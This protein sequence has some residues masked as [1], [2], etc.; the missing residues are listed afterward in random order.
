MVKLVIVES[1][2]KAKLIQKFLGDEYIVKACFG[3]I[4]NL[5]EKELGI[6]IENGFEPTYQI[7]GDKKKLVAELKELA[8]KSDQV[9]ISSDEDFEG[10]KIGYDLIKQFKLPFDASNRVVFHEITKPAILKAF[11]S[12]QKLNINRANCALSRRIADRLIGYKI[13]PMLWKFLKGLGSGLSAGRVQSAAVKLVGEKEKEITEKIENDPESY[14]RGSGEF[15]NKNGIELSGSLNPNLPRDN[16]DDFLKNIVK[17]KFTISDINEKEEQRNPPPP[18]VTVSLQQDASVKL[19]QSPKQIMSMAQKLYENGKITY[20]RTDSTLLSEEFLAK[21]GDYI[22]T[23]YG[24]E[25]HRYFQYKT[26]SKSAQEAHEAIRPTNVDCLSLD[27]EKFTDKEIGLYQLI[28][29]RTVQSQMSPAKYRIFEII[30]NISNIEEH[31]YDCRSEFMIFDGFHKIDNI[32]KEL[33]SK[34]DE[35]S[36]PEKSANCS[37][38]SLDEFAKIVS[39]LKKGEEFSKVKLKLDE[40]FPGLPA[41]YTE[42]TLIKALETHGIGRPSTM[43]SIISTI[44]EKSYVEKKNF[45]GI[46][47]DIRIIE[48]SKKNEIKEKKKTQKIG[49][50]KN[51]LTITPIGA[52]IIRFLEENFPEIIDYKFTSK[53]EKYL[54]KI[55]DGKYEWKDIIAKLWSTIEPKLSE[56]EGQKVDSSEIKKKIA[57]INGGEPEKKSFEL[58][59]IS[60]EKVIVR[61]ARY[62][63]VIQVGTEKGNIKYVKIPSDLL[64][65]WE[66]LDFD[67]VKKII[68]KDKLNTIDN[69]GTKSK[70]NGLTFDEK[71]VLI[72]EGKYG[73]YIQFDGKNYGLGKLGLTKQYGNQVSIPI[74]IVKEKISSLPEDNPNETKPAFTPRYKK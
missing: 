21:T 49:A 54:D 25:Y 5:P 39:S 51:K 36:D 30:L 15:L 46:K 8:R 34:D 71:G 72:K 63:P 47:K 44:T 53:F 50:E 70:S 58:G 4:M 2:T 48:I 11:K 13:S 68:N 31:T 37:D 26:K 28:W 62:G 23:N 65:K 24:D 64:P 59:E 3:H 9:F 69:N 40:T 35:N 60:G 67:T 57:E 73:K 42:A 52:E 12:P 6:D 14:F 38:K 74:N 43:A 18:Y 45:E 33:V 29:K 32:F 19:R 55:A 7:M 41:R 17:S 27:S 61:E 20:M 1:V 22:K 10:E 16:I 56:L 66:T